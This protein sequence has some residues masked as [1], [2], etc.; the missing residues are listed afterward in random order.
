MDAAG[1]RLAKAWLPEG[2]AGI[3]RLHAVI[4]ERAGDA[5]DDDVEVLLGLETDR[6]LWLL[7]L[8][9][10]GKTVLAVKQLQAGPLRGRLGVSGRQEGRRRWAHARRQGPP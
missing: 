6:G 10:A 2:V 3:A 8:V 9:A 4:A 7:A 5:A 1:R